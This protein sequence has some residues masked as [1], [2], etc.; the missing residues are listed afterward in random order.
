MR[1]GNYE[2]VLQLATGGMA[3]VFVARQIGAAGFERLVVVKRVHRHLLSNH[4]FYDMFRD[5]ARVASLVR[6]PNVVPVID[7]VEADGELFL[8]QEYVESTALSTL[9]KAAN[10]AGKPLSPAVVVRIIADTLAGLHAA[11][12]AVDMRGHPLEVVHRDVSPQNIVVGVDGGSRLIDFGVAKARHRIT[13]TKSGSLKGKYGYMSPEQ[14]KAQPLDRRADLFS[15]GVVL[16]EALTG[17]RLF[18]GENEYDT[19]RRIVEGPIP[20]PSSMGAPVSPDVD[21]V[22]AKSLER[23]PEKR[24]Q[25]AAEFLEALEHALRPATPREV[26]MALDVHCGARLTDRREAL[27]DALEGGVPSGEQ[28]TERLTIPS[29]PSAIRRSAE[30]TESQIAST[31]DARIPKVIAAKGR[32][33]LILAMS[34][35]AFAI[36]LAAMV[37]FL[38]ARSES[39]LDAKSAAVTT[40]TPASQN[41]A[42]SAMPTASSPIEIADGIEL[43]LHADAPIESVRAAGTQRLEL[44]GNSATLTVAPWSG[45]LTIDADLAGARGAH[46]D[47]RATG[48]RDLTLQA[49]PSKPPSSPPPS[50]RAKPRPGA[51]PTPP[52]SELQSNPYGQP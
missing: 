20:S 48:P 22:V 5:E 47:A 44:H 41:V 12:E 2:P 24:F 43:V 26:T 25:T 10:D 1:L 23:D 35:G 8:V 29:S 49:P 28:S 9:W 19:L 7:V 4:E 16:H 36:A 21:A 27:R 33:T 15:A 17:K 18:Q 46:V 51:S 31:Q 32:R 37:I 6:H 30:S 39:K 3:T 14:T 45:T 40:S 50:H 38:S 13:E 42:A 11:H 52:S 34:F